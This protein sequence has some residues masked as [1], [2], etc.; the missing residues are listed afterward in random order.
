MARKSTPT[1]QA[2]RM[3][4]LVPFISSHQGISTTELAAEFGIPVDELLGDLNSL[5]MCGDNRFD[6]IDLCACILQVDLAIFHLYLMRDGIV[7]G[8]F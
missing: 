7:H 8:L 1:E 5:W 3:L 2:A 6:L 4:D